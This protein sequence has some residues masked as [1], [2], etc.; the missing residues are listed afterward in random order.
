MMPGNQNRIQRIMLIQKCFVILFCFRYT[1]RN[2]KRIARI[3][4][5]SVLVFFAIDA[6]VN[7]F[8]W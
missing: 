8:G 5:K 6:S 1:A 3:T 2:G 4:S 7:G